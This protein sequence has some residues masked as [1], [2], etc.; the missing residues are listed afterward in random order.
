MAV[1]PEIRLREQALFVEKVAE[2]CQEAGLPK[3]TVA[4]AGLTWVWTDAAQSRS[5][6]LTFD[7]LGV[8]KLVHRSGNVAHREELSTLEGVR[9]AAAQLYH[10]FGSVGRPTITTGELEK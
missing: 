8:V 4:R 2:I 6:Q 7:S 1:W 5:A 10:V 9:A 3:P